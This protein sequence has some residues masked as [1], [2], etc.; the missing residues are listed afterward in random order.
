MLT[1]SFEMYPDPLLLMRSADLMHSV[2]RPVVGGQRFSIVYVTQ[3]DMSDLEVKKLP[4]TPAEMKAAIQ[5]A[6]KDDLVKRKAEAAD[7]DQQPEDKRS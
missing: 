4:P 6:K 1:D 7:N 2:R 3:R 5:D